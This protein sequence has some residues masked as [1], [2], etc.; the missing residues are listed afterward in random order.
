MG[1]LRSDP[2][3]S[4]DNSECNFPVDVEVFGSQLV[5]TLTVEWR[6]GFHSLGEELL[7][8]GMAS[9]MMSQEMGGDIPALGSSASGAQEPWTEMHV[10]LGGVVTVVDDVLLKI[11][12]W[13]GRFRREK[14]EGPAPDRGGSP[15]ALKRSAAA[16]AR[17]PGPVE[18]APQLPSL[19]SPGSS[20]GPRKISISS[21]SPGGMRSTSRPRPH[22]PA[23]RANCL[24]SVL[25]L[26][27]RFEGGFGR[28]AGRGALVPSASAVML[29][30]RGNSL[31]RATPP[32][33]HTPHRADES[34]SY[35]PGLENLD[36]PEGWRRS[37]SLPADELP[38]PM[39]RRRKN[40]IAVGGGMLGRLCGGGDLDF[41]ARR[42]PA[43]SA[44]A[45]HS[46]LSLSSSARWPGRHL[47]QDLLPRGAKKAER[48]RGGGADAH[49]GSTT[50]RH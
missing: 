16:T 20:P 29:I 44:G 19:N 40:V 48:S 27:P 22:H 14:A 28:A 9:K 45:A 8:T 31:Q 11:R 24:I 47:H 7:A 49:A 46:P 37:M 36:G 34:T 32:P 17:P 50:P 26:P 21:M 30:F 10:L 35:R 4:A 15:V 6:D 2:V 23:P 43:A 1:K 39:R 33:S 13:R 12:T 5:N 18:M 41:G 38:K 42:C 25:S 3:A